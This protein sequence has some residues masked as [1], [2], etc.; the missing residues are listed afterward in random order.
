MSSTS[1]QITLSNGVTRTFSLYDSKSRVDYLLALVTVTPHSDTTVADLF[2]QWISQ[3]LIERRDFRRFV[4]FA[5][6]EYHQHQEFV[7]E[8]NIRDAGFP[9][10]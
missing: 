10:Y 9:S 4:L 7:N 8:R 5:Q 1:K 3:G 2:W 6:R